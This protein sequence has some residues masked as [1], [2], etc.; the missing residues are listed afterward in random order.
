MNECNFTRAVKVR[1]GVFVSFSTMCG[2]TSVSNSFSIYGEKIR[3]LKERIHIYFCKISLT[4]MMTSRDHGFL[5][6]KL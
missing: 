6:D 3:I 5:L 4:D 1:V 2:P